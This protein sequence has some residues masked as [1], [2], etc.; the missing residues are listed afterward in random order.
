MNGFVRTDLYFSYLIG[1]ASHY[2]NLFYINRN[3]CQQLAGEQ[4]VHSHAQAQHFP[5]FGL[6]AKPATLFSR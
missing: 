6:V 3:T 1:E 4:E 2:F 5:H